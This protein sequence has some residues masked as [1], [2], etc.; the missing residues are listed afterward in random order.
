[1][2]F[3]HIALQGVLHRV[4]RHRH[5]APRRVF[6]ERASHLL[7][8]APKIA[9]HRDLVDFSAQRLSRSG[10]LLPGIT[11]PMHDFLKLVLV[12]RCTREVHTARPLYL[13][14]RLR[15][16]QVGA[17]TSLGAIWPNV[18]DHVL[19]IRL[20]LCLAQDG[21]YRTLLPSPT[22]MAVSVP[23]AVGRGWMQRP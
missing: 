6:L 20:Q 7:I 2:V 8:P 1:M 23:R 10:E 15:F 21:E 16:L 13:E 11:G 18:L 19:N 22:T 4:V 14:E 9:I 3:I 17:E 12:C 5:I